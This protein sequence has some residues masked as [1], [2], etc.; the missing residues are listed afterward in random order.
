[1]YPRVD[2]CIHESC[3]QPTGVSTSP[4]APGHTSARVSASPVRVEDPRCR[5][6]PVS[7]Q[8]TSPAYS[9]VCLRARPAMR[10]RPEP[11]PR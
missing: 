9:R 3:I 10:Y 6:S 4:G 2:W 7:Q 8:R 5:A 1:M 11:D